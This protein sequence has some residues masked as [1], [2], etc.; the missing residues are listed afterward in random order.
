MIVVVIDFD[1]RCV[2]FGWNIVN[3]GWGNVIFFLNNFCFFKGVES[4][5]INF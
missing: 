5:W 3:W 4:L 2:L 1:Y